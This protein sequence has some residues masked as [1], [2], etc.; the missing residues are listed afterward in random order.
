MFSG[1]STTEIGTLS[2][3]GVFVG[4]FTFVVGRFLGRKERVKKAH[5][6]SHRALAGQAAE[7]WAPFLEGFPGHPSDARFLGAPIDYLVFDGL[8]E[9]DVNEVVFVEVKSGKSSLST[10]ERRLRDCIR[11]GRVRWVEHRV[12]APR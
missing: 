11:E 9:G 6:G 10:T 12:D 8:R 4:W 3:A 7:Q 1:L 2:L 5:Q